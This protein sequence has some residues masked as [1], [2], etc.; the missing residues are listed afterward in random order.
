MS[1]LWRVPCVHTADSRSRFHRLPAFPWDSLYV[2]KWGGNFDFQYKRVFVLFFW[3]FVW[4]YFQQNFTTLEFL[5]YLEMMEFIGPQ[6]HWE[7]YPFQVYCPAALFICSQLLS[8]FFLFFFF[9]IKVI[10]C[11]I[12]LISLS[13]F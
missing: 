10:Y 4:K 3:S 2:S 8:F 9:L 12:L 13:V 6:V 7:M 5:I 1:E 11:R